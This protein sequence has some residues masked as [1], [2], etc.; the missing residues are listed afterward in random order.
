[1]NVTSTP[2]QIPNE[3]PIIVLSQTVLF[4]N[5]LLPLHIFEQRYC[6]MLAASLGG[7]RIFG[8]AQSNEWNDPTLVVP[9]LA[10]IMGIGVIRACVGRPDG[11][12]DLILQGLSRVKIIGETQ[13]EPFRIVEIESL[14]TEIGDVERVQMLA[15]TLCEQSRALSEHGYTMPRQ[16]DQYMANIQDPEIIG[17][18]MAAAFVEDPEIRQEILETIDLESRLEIILAAMRLLNPL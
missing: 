2:L 8:V 12:S 18:L 3:I 9:N 17:D 13:S 15:K 6:D 16:M 14:S 4:P 1:M 11:T 7:P 10:E 5:S